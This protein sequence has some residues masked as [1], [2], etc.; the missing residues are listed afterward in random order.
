M[1][2]GI[3]QRRGAVTNATVVCLNLERG[4]SR[5]AVAAETEQHTSGYDDQDVC[6]SGSGPRVKATLTRS[7]ARHPLA[8]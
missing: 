6:P 7:V 2:I 4:F 1:G 3:R 8:E 5:Q